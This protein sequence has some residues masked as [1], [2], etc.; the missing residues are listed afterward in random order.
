MASNSKIEW[1]DAT[2]NPIVGCTKVSQGCKNCYAERMAYRLSHALGK[3]GDTIPDAWAAYSNVITG[4]GWNGLTDIVPDA[5]DKPLHWKKPRR[6]FVCSMGDLF[7]ET[8]PFNWIAKVWDRIANSPQHTFLI[9]TKRPERMREFMSEYGHFNY[10]LLPNVWLGVSVENQDWA[11]IR[12]PILLQIPAIVR[13]VSAEPLLGYVNL[14]K[15]KIGDISYIDALKGFGYGEM[16][17]GHKLHYPTINWVIA[18]GESGNK[19]RPMHPDWA[20]SI[21]D[22]CMSAGVP[23]F[24][25]QWGEWAPSHAL[26]CNLPDFKGKL[27]MNF[28]PDIS[29]CKIGRKKAGNKLDGKVYN[30]Y[31]NA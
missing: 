28:D 21:R 3:V 30:E 22:Q 1:T 5:L 16:I 17:D 15:I 4:K 27:W 6:V 31:P 25:K 7:H 18:G 24:F 11:N 9:L 23:F 29:V 2:W 20:V 13:F 8:I 10:G 19:A 14:T 26:N 12:V